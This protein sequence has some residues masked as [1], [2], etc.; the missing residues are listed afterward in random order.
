MESH[1]VHEDV[2]S[3]VRPIARY[4]G[5]FD[6]SGSGGVGVESGLGVAPKRRVC[7]LVLCSCDVTYV[8]SPYSLLCLAQ[9]PRK[10]LI[11]T[12]IAIVSAKH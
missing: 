4:G 10:R 2:P 11:P 5:R 6:E 3:M 12:I 9:V 1:L 7:R 8:R